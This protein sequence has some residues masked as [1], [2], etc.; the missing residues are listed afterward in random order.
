MKWTEISL[1][2]TEGLPNSKGKNVILVVVDRLTKYA[3]F[4]PLAHPYSVQ[5]V[6]ELFFDNIIKLHGPPSMIVSDRDR[7][8]TSKLWN[9]FFGALQTSLHFSTA[10]H[11]ESDEQTEC[12][13]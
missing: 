4:L 2:I 8:F 9:E 6:A 1:D 5:T 11:P 13:N 12:V 7:I 10:Y 3:H